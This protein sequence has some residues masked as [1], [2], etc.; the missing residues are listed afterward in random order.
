MKIS[1]SLFPTLR[2]VFQSTMCRSITNS[3]LGARGT[4]RFLTMMLFACVVPPLAFAQADLQLLSLDFEPKTVDAGSALS[5]TSW[6]LLNNGPETLYRPTFNFDFFL[7][8]N[9]VPGDADDQKIDSVSIP[10]P[11]FN[12]PPGSAA[13]QAVQ[14][15][16]IPATASGDYHVVTRVLPVGTDLNTN[17]NL[18]ASS[19]LL[20]VNGPPQIT[21]NPTSQ[22]VTE[23]Q[24]G[25]FTVQAQGAAPLRYQWYKDALEIADATNA[26]LM[27]T[28]I[29]KGN[30][31]TYTVTVGNS[32]GSAVS[33]GATLTVRELAVS[34][35]LFNPQRTNNAF[36]VSVQ[37]V[38]NR[39]YVLQYKNL[40]SDPIWIAVAATSGDGTVKTL[41]DPI[42][43]NNQRF[44]R[45]I[46][47]DQLVNSFY[48]GDS[49]PTPNGEARLYRSSS[50]F[51]VRAADT[52]TVQQL[53]GPGGPLNGFTTFFQVGTN[54]D[55]YQ[56]Q[57]PASPG[58]SV[59][60]YFSSLSTA[61]AQLGTDEVLPVFVDPRSGL[62]MIPTDEIIVCL[63]TGV[64]AQT[65][66]GTNW[67]NVRPLSGMSEQF[68]E[69]LP[70][71]TAA[72]MLGQ[73]N[74]RAAQPGAAWA[75]PN[76]LCQLARHYTPDDPSFSTQWHLGDSAQGG[77]NATNAWEFTK[78]EGVVIGIID[79]GFDLS[80]PELA[81]RVA[82]NALEVPGD[83]LDNDGNGYTNDWR[84]WD[85]AGAFL[86]FGLYTGIEDNDPR[87]SSL[88]ENHGTTV[89]GVALAEGNNSFG[90]AGVA[91][92][93]RLLPVRVR[94]SGN[95]GDLE[96]TTFAEL[97]S[98]AR[99]INYAAG[100]TRDGLGTW[101]GADVINMSLGLP[102]PDAQGNAPGGFQS[103]NTALHWAAGSGRQGRGCLIF[104][105]TGNSASAWRS[106]SLAGF[107][108]GRYTFRWEYSKNGSVSM[109]DDTAW[110]DRIVFPGGRPRVLKE[111]GRAVGPLVGT[112]DGQLFR[113][114]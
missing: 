114:A 111:D 104:A 108:A 52:N 14:G 100:K 20:K 67:L 74:A 58:V 43:N 36:Q 57:A 8:R 50:N 106:Y 30:A 113:M 46:I 25:S 66:F 53:T 55:L 6:Y 37:T 31:G 18:A 78:G 41:T 26:V 110:L 45:V 17:N 77:V 21:A 73:V 112:P 33:A 3:R 80:H 75:E 47:A 109:G 89:A 34:L 87:P 39:T 91:F 1:H 62:L 92:Q 15:I 88:G 27:L 24:S 7:S 95:L 19:G 40:L 10:N 54:L 99:A 68:V 4:R 11:T 65:F 44:Y 9:A 35:V 64:V 102:E 97:D 85:F 32:A 16:R 42:A 29:Q 84:G 51:F 60:S 101:R 105:A 63:Q 83:G 13:M 103:L 61:T 96:N 81:N 107:S 72:Q 48:S 90:G 2:T 56:P 93:S 82:F 12:W 86:G 70:G 23:G 22:T 71:A 76:L 59:D 49:Y 94:T 28:N 69:K 38:T 98:W 79:D 5:E